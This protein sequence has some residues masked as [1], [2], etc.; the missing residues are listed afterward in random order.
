M[1]E[2]TDDAEPDA[3]APDAMTAES[4]GIIDA[5]VP[6]ADADPEETD[7]ADLKLVAQSRMGVHVS[8]AGPTPI[9]PDA[10]ETLSNEVEDE[11]DL[12]NAPDLDNRQRSA[13]VV[14]GTVEYTAT[15]EVVDYEI[16][17][18]YRSEYA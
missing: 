13:E 4:A 1:P 15:G 10:L 9:M 12:S 11:T 8:V 2:H 18:E 3:D 7:T 17:S 5:M 14:I 16:D 6:D